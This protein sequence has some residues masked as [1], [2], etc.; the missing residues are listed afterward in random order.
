MK[1]KK[2]SKASVATRERHKQDQT[3]TCTAPECGLYVNERDQYIKEAPDWMHFTCWV[4]VRNIDWDT[5]LEDVTD[6]EVQRLVRYLQ[7]AGST[8]EAL[9]DDTK[10]DVAAL[11]PI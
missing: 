8:D 10:P 3:H 1:D 9:Q 11:A 5:E 6:R 7:R 4:R 2:W